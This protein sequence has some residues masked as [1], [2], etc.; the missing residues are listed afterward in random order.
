MLVEAVVVGGSRHE[1]VG[2]EK[3]DEIFV[4]FVICLF[5][6]VATASDFGEFSGEMLRK[7]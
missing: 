4:I 1:A 2:G 3:V 7:I 6:A 5:N